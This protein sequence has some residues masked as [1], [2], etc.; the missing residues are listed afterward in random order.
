[1]DIYCIYENNS[2]ECPDNSTIKI[3]IL[4]HGKII[5]MDNISLEKRNNSYIIYNNFI[6][7]G[8]IKKNSEMEYNN[9]KFIIDKEGFK[10]LSK[11]IIYFN[12]VHDEKNIAT[13]NSF[14]NTLTIHLYDNLNKI[15]VFIYI[16]ILSKKLK[17]IHKKI[18]FG[19]KFILPFAAMIIPTIASIE[20][21]LNINFSFFIVLISLIL[22]LFP[23]IL[24]LYYSFQKSLF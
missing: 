9:S 14:K 2:I 21:F 1:M 17:V 7:T 24:I 8:Y 12:I 11:G 20:S 22:I 13:I 6:E 19:K 15:P 16:A 5:K 3:K 10:K 18:Y 23:F 4:E